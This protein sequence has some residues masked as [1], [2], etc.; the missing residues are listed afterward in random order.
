MSTRRRFS[1]DFKAKL[2]LEALREDKTMQEFATRHKVQ[3]NQVSAW[4]QRAVDGMEGGL[5]EGG[6]RS[7]GAT[8]RRSGT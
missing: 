6:E 8:R 2:A 4:K 7:L 3:P 5:L 1:R